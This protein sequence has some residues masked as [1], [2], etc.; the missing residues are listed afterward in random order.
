MLCSG[1]KESNDRKPLVMNSTPNFFKKKVISVAMFELV[2]QFTFNVHFELNL[3][4][5][6]ITKLLNQ[7]LTAN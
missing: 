4:K 5:K 6:E 2:I 1:K 3:D 7:L